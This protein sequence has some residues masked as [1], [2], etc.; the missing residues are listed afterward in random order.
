MIKNLRDELSNVFKMK[1]LC[2]TKKTLGMEIHRD[3]EASKLHLS[4]R[5][6]LEKVLDRFNMSK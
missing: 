3:R 5:K 6:Y 1:N 2:T 4:Q